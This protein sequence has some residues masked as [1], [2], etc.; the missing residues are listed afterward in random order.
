MTLP[1][2]AL[3]PTPGHAVR[4]RGVGLFW[5]TFLLLSAWIAI[6]TLAWVQTLREADQGPH[7]VHTARHLVSLVRVVR[8]ALEHLPADR[9]TPFFQGLQGGEHL[10][11]V[12][13]HADDRHQPLAD[14]AL[15]QRIAEAVSRL[16][17]APTPLATSVNGAQ[18]LWILFDTHAGSYWL[19]ADPALLHPLVDPV[20]LAWLWTAVGFSLVGAVWLARWV[21]LPVARLSFAT[22]RIR[23]GDFAASTLDESVQAPELRD[24]H[25]GFNRMAQQLAR[26]DQDRAV[27][28]AGISHDLRTPLGHLRLEIELA[29]PD[30]QSRANMV[31]DIAQL[32]AIVD[33]F[34][35]YARPGQPHAQPVALREVL[36]TCM[37]PLRNNKDVGMVLDMTEDLHVLG[38][39]V[40]LARI[41]ANL[42][43]NAARYG[44]SVDTGIARIALHAHGEG[45]DVVLCVRDHGI[46]IADAQID[47]ITTPF[48]RGEAARTATT[49]AGLGL[50]IV[51]RLVLRMAGT[52]QLRNAEEGGLLVRIVLPS[53]TR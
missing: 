43:E 53:A 20:R 16:L 4:R 8:A 42:L 31:R 7:A 33:K 49:G 32:D 26:I 52:L 9:V 30:P 14:N 1:D 37:D 23:E 22:S 25:V 21:N 45:D 15:A 3:P 17:G 40:E 13:H 11:V 34:L 35:D 41:I 44:K 51:E 2:S 6:S 46:G 5:R 39:P 28:L 24:V 29:V 18:G 50:A 12:P 47:Q 19:R 10:R 38:D 36:A 27:M 48:F